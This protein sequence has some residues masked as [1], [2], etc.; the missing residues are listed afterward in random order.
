MG[1]N[2]A[3]PRKQI[4]IGHRNMWGAGRVAQAVQCLSRNIWGA[5]EHPHLWL[6][7]SLFT[8]LFFSVTCFS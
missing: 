1:Q 5:H 2:T 3:R 6:S 4:R 7:Q 8:L